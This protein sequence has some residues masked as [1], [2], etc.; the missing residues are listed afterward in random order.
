[1]TPSPPSDPRSDDALIEAINEGDAAAFEALYHRYRD[2]VVRLAYRFTGNR[3]DALDVLQDAFAYL[4]AEFPGFRLTARMTTFLYPVVKHRSLAIRRKRRPFAPGDDAL[5]EPAAVDPPAPG[6][7]RSELAVVMGV[8]PAAQREIILMRFVD[9]MP[10]AEIA[11]A[12]DTPLGTVK[13]SLHRA[14]ATLREDRRTRHYFE[15]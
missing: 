11:A 7:S 15:P 3:D 2:W 9:G 4:L 5:P 10:L 12:L 13:S 6:S 1:M 14:L 8:L